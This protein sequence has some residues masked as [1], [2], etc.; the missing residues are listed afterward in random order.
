M[1]SL[2]T[3]TRLQA[4]TY[5]LGICLF[6]ISFLVFL[7]SSVSFV[8]TDLIGQGERVGDAVGTLGFAD[9]LVALIACPVW[10]MVS[11]RVG[12]RTV[13]VVGY[14][15]VGISL[16]VFV[17]SRNVYPQLLFGRLLF[18]LGGAATWVC[19]LPLEGW[20]RRNANCI[21]NYRSTMVTAI[22]P[23]M[24]F[25][26]TTHLSLSANRRQTISSTDAEAPESITSELTITPSR[27]QSHNPSAREAQ[28]EPKPSASASKLAGI[29]GML[30]GIGALIA[31]SVFLPLPTR[32]QNGGASRA[33]SLADAFYVVGSIALLVSV[34]VYFGLRN[35]PGE[36][37]KSWKKLLNPAYT[38]KPFGA[39]G[40]ELPL[41]LPSY[42]KLLLTSMALGFKD[43]NIGLGYI[44]GFVARASS[45]AISLFIPLFVNAYFISSGRCPSDSLPT[46]PHDP[47]QIRACKRA[48]T[49]AAILSGVSQLVALCCA[50]LF[51]YLAVYGTRY[52]VPLLV[53]SV[54]GILGYTLFANIG[55]PDPK[56]ENGKYH[57]APFFIVALLGISQIGAIVCSLGQL[58]KGIETD[59]VDVA[60]FFSNGQSLNGDSARPSLETRASSER[61]RPNGQEQS[62]L[63]PSHLRYISQDSSRA[64][65]KGSI[66][67]MYS[68]A[69]GAGILLLTKV[70][71]LMFDRVDTGGPFYLMAAFN[72]VLFCV[73]LGCGVWSSFRGEPKSYLVLSSE[74]DGEG[75][76]RDD[77]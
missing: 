48:Y 38:A 54:S 11:D 66:A 73:T 29:V 15:I 5:L 8:I 7:N 76:A 65:L 56:D 24:T 25:K 13:A 64:K 42:G 34:F 23:A 20:T 43:M 10:G 50:P 61:V 49:V 59:D 46:M 32:F 67:G 41:E 71:G 58:A 27:F 55:D 6:S 72:A 19:L 52:N 33:Q 22:L 53:A 68:L 3:A 44:G 39:S 12:V 63:I 69:G 2:I 16:M 74:E 9:E 51:G 26:N 21:M 18:S 77:G 4:T 47:A 60:D 62:P 75:L 17:Q 35:L 30:T 31:L 36:E 37:E 28:D 40:R 70:G 57:Y 45:V 1:T 14:A